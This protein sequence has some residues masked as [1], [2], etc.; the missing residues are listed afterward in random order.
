MEINWESFRKDFEKAVKSVELKYNVELSQ[1]TISYDSLT[2]R[3]TVDGV[4][5]RDDKDAEQLMFEK[6]CLKYGVSPDKYKAELLVNGK[7]MNLVGF[8]PRARKYPLILRDKNGKS[9]KYIIN[10]LDENNLR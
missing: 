7:L 9:Y 8:N 1:K 10:C 6:Y 3:F 2:F 4:R 5:L